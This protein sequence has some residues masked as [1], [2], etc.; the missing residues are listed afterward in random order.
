[1]GKNKLYAF[2]SPNAFYEFSCKI[3]TLKVRF[4]TTVKDQWIGNVIL[5]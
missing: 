4:L 2:P 1:M 5:T 3:L